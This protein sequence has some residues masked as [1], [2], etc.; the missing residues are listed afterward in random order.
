MSLSFTWVYLVYDPDTKLHKIGRSD[1]PEV[2]L[3]QLLRD[4]TKGPKPR[5]WVLE[6]AWL[7]PY[8]TEESLHVQYGNFHVHGEWFDL[9]AAYDPCE[10]RQIPLIFGAEFE[11]C[12]YWYPV[13]DGDLDVHQNYVLRQ[14]LTQK[15]DELNRLRIE[16]DEQRRFFD[17]REGDWHRERDRLRDKLS[18]LQERGDNLSKSNVAL[19]DRCELLSARVIELE[20][21]IRMEQTRRRLSSLPSLSDLVKTENKSGPIH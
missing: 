17:Q 14:Q 21:P 9:F 5:E 3:K 19:S 10:R 7:L 2:R 12:S 18:A 16:K 6:Q 15:E 20:N 1:D 8:G 4:G 13:D 11:R